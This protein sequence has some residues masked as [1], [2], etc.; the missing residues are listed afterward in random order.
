MRIISSVQFF[1]CWAI[2]VECAVGQTIDAGRGSLPI[3]VPLG[4][5][6]EKPAPLVVLL[7]GYTGNGPQQDSY[8]KVSSLAHSYGFLFVVPNGTRE[9]SG[10]RNRF[11]NGTEAC[12]DFFGSNVEDSTYIRRLIDEVT[13]NYAV[14]ANRVFLIGHSNGGFMSHRLAVDHPDTIAAIASLAGAAPNK[15]T[16]VKPKR[17]VN[18]LQIHGTK[19]RLNL[20]QGGQIRDVKYPGAMETV[21]KWAEFYGWST[22]ATSPPKKL[23]LDKQLEGNE[24]T[25]TQYGNGSVELWTIH[26]GGHIPALSETFTKHVI[27]WLMAHPK[28]ARN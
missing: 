16:G 15:L 3:V 7:H 2:A 24:S 28:M 20:Y 5:E 14:D 12:C 25:I 10:A 4:Y 8:M 17:P 26:D 23:D 13:K 21:E 27:E 18:I 11:W 1:V 6:Q 19:D 22:K 9:E